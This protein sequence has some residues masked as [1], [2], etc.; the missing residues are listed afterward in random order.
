LC[1]LARRSPRRRAQKAIV[2]ARHSPAAPSGRRAANAWP[3]QDRRITRAR[4]VSRAALRFGNEDEAAEIIGEWMMEL[5]AGHGGTD[6]FDYFAGLAALSAAYLGVAG[7]SDRIFAPPAAWP[8]GGGRIGL[9]AGAQ[10]TP[11]RTG[12]SQRGWC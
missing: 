12:L 3:P 5:C 11:D 1:W 6:G 8:A 7:G 2:D 10:T 4:P 9:P